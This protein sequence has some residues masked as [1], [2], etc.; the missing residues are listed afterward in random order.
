MAY[1]GLDVK[2]ITHIA[3]LTRIRSK[4]WIE[5]MLA[6]ATRHDPDAGPWYSQ[7]A[8]VFTPDD[9]MMHIVVDS[10]SKRS[11]RRSASS[12]FGAAAA[13]AAVRRWNLFGDLIPVESGAQPEAFSQAGKTSPF[14]SRVVPEKTPS[15]IESENAPGY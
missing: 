5:Q 8:H 9:K 6:R 13:A 14:E 4:P 2:P 11:R 1:E 10:R 3:C 12:A 15:E 7:E